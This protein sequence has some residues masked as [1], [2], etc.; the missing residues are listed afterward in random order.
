MSTHILMFMFTFTL[1]WRFD[2]GISNLASLCVCCSFCLAVRAPDQKT[3]AQ[4]NFSI[5]GG[6]AALR[7]RHLLF[8][9]AHLER[10][11]GL[12]ATI[13]LSSVGSEVADEL[14]NLVIAPH[15]FLV[16]L[17]FPLNI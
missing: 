7:C 15:D 9:L 14:G 1:A 2:S 17:Q 5:I 8:H 13:D 3:T 12:H 11:I 16:E 4:H 10:L 6:H